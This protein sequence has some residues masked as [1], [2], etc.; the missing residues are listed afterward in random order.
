M[1]LTRRPVKLW[2]VFSYLLV[3]DPESTPLTVIAVRHGAR[4]VEQ[5]LPGALSQKD[6]ERRSHQLATRLRNVDREH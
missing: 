5:L 2:S 1:N 3:Y 6:S 4:D